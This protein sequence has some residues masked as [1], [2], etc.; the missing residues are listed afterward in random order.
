[1]TEFMGAIQNRAVLATCVEISRDV[2]QGDYYKALIS[3][4][5]LFDYEQER[6]NYEPEDLSKRA[7]RG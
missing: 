2:V 7:A 5:K 3:C 1:M 4:R 6:L